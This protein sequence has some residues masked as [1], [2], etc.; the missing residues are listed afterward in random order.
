MGA[1][2]FARF[3]KDVH[4]CNSDLMVQSMACCRSAHL[5]S[6]MSS[7]KAFTAPGLKARNSFEISSY[8]E[9]AKSSETVDN[10]D[11]RY[12]FKNVRAS[13][14]MARM[15][16]PT[17]RLRSFA[18]S[19]RRVSTANCWRDCFSKRVNRLDS[20]LSCCLILFR[21]S[22]VDAMAKRKSELFSRNV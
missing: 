2:P 18:S 19:S 16:K 10:S 7:V 15:R 13:L 20:S 3:W 11:Y 6:S 22:R 9:S 17:R 14:A 1:I 12:D 8:S 21:L 5:V 4:A